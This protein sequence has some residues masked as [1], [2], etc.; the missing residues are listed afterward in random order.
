MR[1]SGGGFYNVYNMHAIFCLYMYVCMFVCMCVCM[2]VCMYVR[3]AH[4][5]LNFIGMGGGGLVYLGA[6][7]VYLYNRDRGSHDH[8]GVS[9]FPP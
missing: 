9:V 8:R 1:L 2:Y 5:F 3:R 4:W 7:Y 6:V